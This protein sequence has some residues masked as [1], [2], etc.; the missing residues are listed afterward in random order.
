MAPLSYKEKQ[1]DL[2]RLFVAKREPDFVVLVQEDQN[3][4]AKA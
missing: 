1:T 2:I 3:F 4:F